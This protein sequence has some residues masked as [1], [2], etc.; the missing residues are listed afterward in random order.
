MVDENYLCR[1]SSKRR[2]L[3]GRVYASDEVRQNAIRKAEELKSK[4]ENAFSAF[5]K[6]M[7]QSHVTGGFWLVLSISSPHIIVVNCVYRCLQCSY[8]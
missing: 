8:I 5:V 4:L 1:Y 2:D 7:L 3:S 6:P